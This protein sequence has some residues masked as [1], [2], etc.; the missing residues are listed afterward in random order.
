MGMTYGEDETM[1][2]F[3]VPLHGVRDPAKLASLV[4]SF[5]TGRPVPA[6]VV[7]GETAL[8]GSHR[9]AAHEIAWR[10]W[11]RQEEGWD[12]TE[13]PTLEMVEVSEDDYLAACRLLGISHHDE[14]EHFDLFAAALY[15]A[16]EDDAVKAAL[17]NQ[18]GYYEDATDAEFARYAA[19]R[20]DSPRST[21][22]DG[23]A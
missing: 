8:T 4:E 2:T 17:V 19:S 13:E 7:Q 10:A 21:D 9:I 1:T 3:L 20:G 22:P 18:R 12:D 16:T 15:T 5:R 14:V 23:A 6:V 11:S